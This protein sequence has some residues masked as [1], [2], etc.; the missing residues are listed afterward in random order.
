MPLLT[1]LLFGLAGL[2]APVVAVDPGEVGGASSPGG[3]GGLDRLLARKELAGVA[4][5]VAAIDVATGRLLVARAVDTPRV[6]ASNMKLVTTAAALSELGSDYNFTTHFMAAA[7]PD[8]DGRLVGDLVI[9][10]GGDPSL[11]ADLLGDLGDPAVVLVDL[12]ESAGVFHVSGRLV[13]DDGFFDEQSTHPDWSDDVQFSFAAPVDA[14]SMHG[15]CLSLLLSGRGSPQARLATAASGYRVRNDLKHGRRPGEYRVGGIRPDADGEV[16]VFGAIGSR[17]GPKE[18]RVPV[19]SGARLFGASIVAEL[20][21]RGVVVEGGW[22]IEPGAAAA[23]DVELARFVSP[24]PNA[25]IMANKES[26]NSISDHLF[27]TIGAVVAG[28]GSFA[29]GSEAITGFLERTVDARVEGLVLRDGSGLSKHNRLTA[30]LLAQVL[31]HM[32]SEVGAERDVYLRS[33]PVAGLDGSL[34]VRLTDE[35]YRGRVRAKTGWIGGASALSGYV[36]TDSG[37]TLAFS[38]LFNKVP[39]GK[40]VDMKAAQDDI[41]RWFVDTL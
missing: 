37:R 31:A 13:L 30:R 16:R 19:R 4:V 23:M 20:E 6:P 9:L 8:D 18:L 28:K 26:D 38:L 25:I 29:G 5:S 21:R 15:N 33:L 41:C 34:S 22:A 2:F 39:P 14:L 40:N 11:R 27:K 32:A 1:A 17:V 3:P 7:R 35:P 24:L 10:G 12:L 36:V